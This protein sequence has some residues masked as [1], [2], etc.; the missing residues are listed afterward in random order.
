MME[1]DMPYK[2]Y[3]RRAPNIEQTDF[4]TKMLLR[5]TRRFQRKGVD[6]A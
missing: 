1:K 4:K 2:Q 5:Q 3:P 6:P